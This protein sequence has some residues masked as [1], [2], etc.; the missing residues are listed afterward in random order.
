MTLQKKHSMQAMAEK[1]HAV[2]IPLKL[3]SHITSMLK[4]AKL[5]HHKG[6]HITFVNT[7]S[8]HGLLLNSR[9][10]DS[11]NG[12]HDFRF[13]T[14]PD[15]VPPSDTLAFSE[16]SKKNQLASFNDLLAK[17]HDT[18]YSGVPPVTCI[19]SDGMM[20]FAI[21]AAEMLGIP[22]A[23]FFTQSASVFMCSKQFR[24][25]KNKGLA[26]LDGMNMK[27]TFYCPLVFED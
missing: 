10:T 17:L 27:S 16:D 15:S 1:P 18:T 19:V 12:L 2:F 21:S 11:L 25:L 23:L 22:I 13:E 6:F 4:L 14:I 24:A 8:S 20:S 5:L 7:E 3:Q 26:P 9:G